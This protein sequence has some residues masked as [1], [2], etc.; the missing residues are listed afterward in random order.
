MIYTF[1]LKQL[2]AFGLEKTRYIS[3]LIMNPALLSLL[4]IN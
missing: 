1:E 2:V 4:P 3:S